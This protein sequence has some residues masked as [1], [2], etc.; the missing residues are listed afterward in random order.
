MRVKLPSGKNIPKKDLN[1]YKSYV[2]NIMQ[3][4]SLLKT[5]LMLMHI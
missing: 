5:K 4:R 3:K 1:R 2:K